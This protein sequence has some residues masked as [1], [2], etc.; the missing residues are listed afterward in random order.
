MAAKYRGF[1]DMSEA[2][3]PD[4]IAVEQK[5]KTWA[6]YDE[7]IFTGDI[8]SKV[9]EVGVGKTR[10][11]AID[12]LC[13]GCGIRYDGF[14]SRDDQGLRHVDPRQASLTQRLH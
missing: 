14:S 13:R 8:N 12:R 6:V 2:K 10:E 1:L 4:L 9:L 3:L 7:S 11:E 5:D